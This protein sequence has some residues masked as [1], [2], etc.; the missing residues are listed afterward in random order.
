MMALVKKQTP[1][2]LKV[3]IDDIHV[4]TTPSRFKQVLAKKYILNP[5]RKRLIKEERFLLEV[6]LY[7]RELKKFQP[8]V[9]EKVKKST[10]INVRQVYPPTGPHYY[11]LAY[12]NDIKI[13]CPKRVFD[14]GYNTLIAL[15]KPSENRTIQT[16]IS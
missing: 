6:A 10:P 12:S 5:R 8:L 14:V 3:F 2:G 9:Y 13:K 15:H 7:E 11:Q 16:A 4:K 1:R